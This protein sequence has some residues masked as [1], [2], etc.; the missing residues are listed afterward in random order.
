MVN[1]SNIPS[2][3][4]LSPEYGGEGHKSCDNRQFRFVRD[5]GTLAA[6]ETN[7]ELAQGAPAADLRYA[8]MAIF[9]VI[10]QHAFA[11]G[12]DR[13]CHADFLRRLNAFSDWASVGA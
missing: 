8:A 13:G 6:G 7:P 4:P 3:L 12:D 5:E 2:H 11:V 1:T 10:D 9:V